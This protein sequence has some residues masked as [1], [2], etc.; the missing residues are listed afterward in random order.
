MRA[1]DRPLE[2]TILAADR[3]PVRMVP[4]FRVAHE[5]YA[6]YWPIAPGLA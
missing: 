2:F 6:T 3:Q 1:G 5:R 4:Y